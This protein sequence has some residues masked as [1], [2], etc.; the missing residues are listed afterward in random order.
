MLNLAKF[1]G[2]DISRLP[3]FADGLHHAARLAVHSSDSKYVIVVLTFGA[4]SILIITLARICL[5]HAAVA[6]HSGEKV[7]DYRKLVAR[8]SQ[9]FWPVFAAGIILNVLLAL[10]A[11]VLFGPALA[12]LHFGYASRGAL[13]FVAATLLFVLA[14]VFLTLVNIFASNFIVVFRLPLRRAVPASVDLLARHWEQACA[15]VAAIGVAYVLV[16]LCPQAH[17]GS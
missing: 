5:I 10:L 16:F 13:L 12:T 6:L 8:S 7:L 2:V 14:W 11:S 1:F 4:V 17:S 3:F 9:N 15:L